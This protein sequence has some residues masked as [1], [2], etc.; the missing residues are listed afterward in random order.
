MRPCSNQLSYSTATPRLHIAPVDTP[1]GLEGSASS[2][3]PSILATLDKLMEP[4]NVKRAGADPCLHFTHEKGKTEVHCLGL[5]PRSLDIFYMSL[6]RNKA[7]EEDGELQGK[8]GLK[9]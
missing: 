5:I 4:Q 1:R 9:G 2:F 3:F 8:Q 7:R 6:Q